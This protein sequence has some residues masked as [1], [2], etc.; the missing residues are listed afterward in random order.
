MAGEGQCID[1]FPLGA[2]PAPIA[3]RES[4][5]ASGS[6][7]AIGTGIDYLGH[8]DDK[9][10]VC[11]DLRMLSQEEI[12]LFGA[13]IQTM[14]LQ[15]GQPMM[16]KDAAGRAV[17]CFR[18]HWE[19]PLHGADAWIRSAMSGCKWCRVVVGALMAFNPSWF[20]EFSESA[21]G[22]GMAH[23]FIYAPNQPGTPLGVTAFDTRQRFIGEMQQSLQ[24]MVPL[25]QYKSSFPELYYP[26]LS[27]A[28]PVCA[29]NCGQEAFSKVKRWIQIC[30]DTHKCGGEADSFVPSRILDIGS[31][32]HGA[33]DA[34]RL[35]DGTEVSGPWAALSYCWGPGAG[36]NV[37]TVKGNLEQ[38]R[39][40]ISTL[41]LP[42]GVFSA[43]QLARS[44][45][46]QFLW[47]DALCIV[48]DD[49]ADW[50]AQVVSMGQVYHH[51]DLVIQNETAEDC[52][53]PMN[54]QHFLRMPNLCTSFTMRDF[55]FDKV[56]LGTMVAK[57]KLARLQRVQLAE[58]LDP[59]AIHVR[60]SSGVAHQ[61]VASWNQGLLFPLKSRG[62][63]LQEGF[64][65]T[66]LLRLSRFEMSWRCLETS[67]C[68]CR[69]PSLEYK[70]R[71]QVIDRFFKVMD[72]GELHI[73]QFGD[74][75]PMK[76]FGGDEGA[77]LVFYWTQ[78]VKDYSTRLLTNPRDRLAAIH[79]LTGIF[80]PGFETLGVPSAYLA[81]HW[82]NGLLESLLWHFDGFRGIKAQLGIPGPDTSAGLVSFNL[83]SSFLAKQND[84]SSL[85]MFQGRDY[86]EGVRS[87]KPVQSLEYTDLVRLI[88]GVLAGQMFPSWSWSSLPFAVNW[89]TEAKHCDPVYA[90]SVRTQFYPRA[91]IVDFAT[92]R[93]EGDL[94]QQLVHGYIQFSGTVYPVQ[95][96]SI[97]ATRRGS[98]TTE[99]I[100]GTFLSI[101]F[102][103][104]TM[105]TTAIHDI[106]FPSGC[107]ITFCPDLPCLFGDNVVDDYHA[108][109]PSLSDS[110]R[111][112]ERRTVEAIHRYTP[113]A[114]IPN[115]PPRA[116]QAPPPQQQGNQPSQ[117]QPTPDNPFAGPT[118]PGLPDRFPCWTR[119]RLAATYN[120]QLSD[121]YQSMLT[122]LLFP[123][124]LCSSPA[125]P[126]RTGWTSPATHPLWALRMGTYRFELPSG[127]TIM[128]DYFLVLAESPFLEGFY[129]RIG[130]AM[131]QRWGDEAG[132]WAAFGEGRE[133]VVAVE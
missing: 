82:Q 77:F 28:S 122:T 115:L 81:G 18:N 57:A 106:R 116:Q 47:I 64:L 128:K 25:Q 118:P 43:I 51:A 121:D 66:R 24:V 11:H 45:G 129:V 117:P 78:L 5:Q 93:P 2:D 102:L 49:P 108:W 41:S 132:G 86:R 74:E 114:E 131:T 124:Q 48:Q 92:V 80:Q 104:A 10:L 111:E 101:D 26:T 126:C 62:W 69:E 54:M 39:Q 63:T 13:R 3:S 65:A 12:E 7:A 60:L 53:Q 32:V 71:V 33:F 20:D 72:L 44:I 88:P 75:G 8:P 36:A 68:E 37:Q 34:V 4:S 21:E 94:K 97:P 50:A 61:H 113:A 22:F 16:M 98:G 40:A 38:H 110:L 55:D 87:G 35:I 85:S 59:D 19:P 119:P 103:L 76:L 14:A 90:E 130:L 58:D 23:K 9:C 120:P 89:P 109:S 123:R 83:A 46:F 125:C 31:V 15:K 133:M 56:P 29:T 1:I 17:P 96:R 112:E 91:S 27:A 6:S 79:G 67:F 73:S 84:Y 99:R 107:V 100:P 42:A 105:S 52:R 70:S 30:K 95:A 127:R